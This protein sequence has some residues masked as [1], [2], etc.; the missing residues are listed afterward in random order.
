MF[1]T[2]LMALFVFRGL[3]PFVVG[4]FL[5]YFGEK[6]GEG[7]NWVLNKG[8]NCFREREFLERENVRW[9][10]P[11]MVDDLK[12]GYKMWVE[13]RYWLTKRR[14]VIIVCVW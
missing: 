6:L 11:M 7:E 9:C 14:V 1:L 10:D 2:K 4:L 3:F 13:T 8:K 12:S 5:G